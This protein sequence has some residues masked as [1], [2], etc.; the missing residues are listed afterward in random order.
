MDCKIE[1]WKPVFPKDKQDRTNFTALVIGRRKMGKTDLMGHFLL[2]YWNKQFDLIM[3]FTMATGIEEYKRFTKSRLIFDGFFPGKIQKIID[4]NSDKGNQKINTLIIFDDTGSRAQKRDAF[5]LNLFMKSRHWNISVVYNI[6]TPT[7]VGPIWR[8]NSNLIFL[9]KPKTTKFREF[10]V[11]NLIAGALN[12]QFESKSKEKQFY[13]RCLMQ[14][15]GVPFRTM[16][17]DF[18]NDEIF[19]YKAPPLK[20]IKRRKKRKKKEEVKE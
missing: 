2:K 18:D 1:T 13:T 15:T 7:L 16:V 10:I 4:F 17:L 5:I 3:I 9:F 11:D 19:K 14:V 8:E 6:Q 20:I 12:I